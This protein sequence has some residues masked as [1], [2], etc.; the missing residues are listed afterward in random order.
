MLFDALKETLRK[1]FSDKISIFPEGKSRVKHFLPFRNENELSLRAGHWKPEGK[2]EEDWPPFRITRDLV[3]LALQNI[4]EGKRLKQKNDGEEI[5][6][7]LDLMIDFET[8]I[9]TKL[10]TIEERMNKKLNII[11]TNIQAKMSDLLTTILTE[12]RNQG[13]QTEADNS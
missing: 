1:F 6:T 10:N 3:K 11:E 12:I 2:W 7:K 9:E 5:N 4:M 8:Q 13:N